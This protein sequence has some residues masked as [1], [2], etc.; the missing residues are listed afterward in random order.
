M[1]KPNL[2]FSMTLT[3]PYGDKLQTW[4]RYTQRL[5]SEYINVNVQGQI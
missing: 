5:T 1:L 4:A 2:V 3:V